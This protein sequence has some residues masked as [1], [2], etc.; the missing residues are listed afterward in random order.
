MEEMILI[1]YLNDFIFCPISIYFHKLYG[2]MENK[3]YNSK[4]QINGINAHKSIDCKK[5]SNRKNILQSI[6]V[7]SYKYN[8]LGK[9]D[10][11]DI[12]KE[13]LTETKNLISHIYDGYIFQVYA[14]YYA[15]TEMGYKVKNINLYSKTD[16]K[17][18]KV[19][20]PY[21][22][23][24]MDNKFKKL[25]NDIKNFDIGNDYININSN[26]CKKCIYEPICDRSGIYANK[27]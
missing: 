7:Y 9:I 21:E 12:D 14:Q 19:K 4:S 20:L 15:L 23:I 22:D 1:S 6:D 18:Y 2:K 27:T 8:I 11:Y 13:T 5:Y 10:I 26:K 17:N 25:I 24:K 3:V 16:N